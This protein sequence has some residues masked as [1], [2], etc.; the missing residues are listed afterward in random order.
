MVDPQFLYLQQKW[1]WQ[2]FQGKHLLY[3][4]LI[5]KHALDNL[6]LKSNPALEWKQ[7]YF[8]VRRKHTSDI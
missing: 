2:I 8:Y 1:S 3:L 5:K 6:E 7:A 4:S